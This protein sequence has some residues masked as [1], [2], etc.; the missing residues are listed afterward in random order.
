MFDILEASHLALYDEGE[1]A[2]GEH[3]E[4]PFLNDGHPG[5][6]VKVQCAL[7]GVEA[8]GPQT[9]DH[10]VAWVVVR[11]FSTPGGPE[12]SRQNPGVVQKAF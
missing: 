11:Q 1:S 4:I 7:G 9:Y 2:G 8:A 5:A 3:V 6:A 12:A 10:N